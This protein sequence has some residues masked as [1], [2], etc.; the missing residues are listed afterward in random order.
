MS[1]AQILQ[2]LRVSEKILDAAT[3]SV[4]VELDRDEAVILDKLLE[5]RTEYS[6]ALIEI[7]SGIEELEEQME[8]SNALACI[9][10]EL[11]ELQEEASSLVAACEELKEISGIVEGE[12]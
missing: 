7:K 12:K 3:N 2:E 8:N 1:E 11:T 9:E 10:V 6:E 4:G 5:Q